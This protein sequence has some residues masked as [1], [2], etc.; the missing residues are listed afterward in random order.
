MAMH[1]FSTP[2]QCTQC[3]TVVNDP[4]L[5]HCP[6]CNALLKERRTP[7]RVAGVER[8][9]GSLRFLLGVLRFLGVIVLLVGVL[10]VLFATGEM[11]AL[12]GTGV[13]LATIMSAVSLFAVAAMFNVLLDIEENTRS[14]FRVQQ[15]LLEAAHPAPRGGRTSAE[16]VEP[17]S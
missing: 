5:D 14:S 16:V 6:Q 13:L 4:T 8:R 3:G 17:A 10:G 11:D 1:L 7:H 12:T 9:Y 2:V 15:M